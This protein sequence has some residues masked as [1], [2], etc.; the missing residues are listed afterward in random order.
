VLFSFLGFGGPY[1]FEHTRACKDKH[2]CTL[3]PLHLQNISLRELGSQDCSA[4]SV[5]EASLGGANSRTCLPLGDNFLLT[6]LLVLIIRPF[7]S[8]GNIPRRGMHQTR[9]KHSTEGVL[10]SFLGFGGPYA[11][12]HTRACK[13][14]HLC[15][16]F[17]L[18][19]QNLSLRELGSQDCSA[20]SVAEAS[21]GG[22]NSRTC[23]P[24]GDI[25][26]L[27]ALLVLIIRPFSSLG[28]IPRRARSQAASARVFGSA[29]IHFS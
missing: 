27:T 26:L 18:P 2:L 4:A 28:N 22:A 13:D 12:E 7:S 17:P 11:F 3:F 16:L 20:A 1:A 25:F 14:K 5:A 29:E 24:L 15:T 8:L 10:F 23:L 6:A 21:L 9:K 19:L